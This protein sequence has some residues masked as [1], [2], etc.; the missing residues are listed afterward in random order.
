MFLLFGMNSIHRTTVTGPA[1]CRFCGQSAIQELTEHG[2]RLTIF[3]IP[4]WTFGRGY[5]AT[6]SACGRQA[7]LGRRDAAV[8]NRT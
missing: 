1:I 6:C 5:R 4:V 2:T 7:R 8:L 3:F